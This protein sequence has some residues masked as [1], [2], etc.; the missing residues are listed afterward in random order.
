[1]SN[2][3]S[4]VVKVFPTTLRK[5]K[6]SSARMMTEFNLTSIINRLVD[7]KCFVIS[8]NRFDGENYVFDSARF[9]FNMGGY[10]FSI[11]SIADILDLFGDGALDTE[12][13]VCTC[14]L[15]NQ[16]GDDPLLNTYYITAEIKVKNHQTDGKENISWN[17]LQ[18]TDTN[19]DTEDLNDDEY[20]GL[21]FDLTTTTPTDLQISGTT[22][23]KNISGNNENITTFKFAILELF[24]PNENTY[25][26]RI[27]EE[28]KLRFQSTPENKS[29]TID[30]GELK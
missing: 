2:L 28:S 17:Q 26:V 5:I 29:F 21:T 14:T 20:S 4:D 11:K 3:K 25:K 15:D 7:K 9:E 12:T 23:T 24:N 1:M 16:A 30:D 6:D 27:P 22:E 18:G 10:Y 19:L 8:S 13:G